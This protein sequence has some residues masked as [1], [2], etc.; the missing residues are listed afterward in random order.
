M[1][2]SLTYSF[3]GNKVAVQLLL[4]DGWGYA[5][6]ADTTMSA[7]RDGKSRHTKKVEFTIP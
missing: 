6:N 1:T 5:E 2:T 3:T 4:C 7:F